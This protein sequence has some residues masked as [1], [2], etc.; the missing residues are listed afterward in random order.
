MLKD[1]TAVALKEAVQVSMTTLPV[2]VTI[3]AL[4][5]FVINTIAVT[6]QT[7]G[8][9]KVVTLLLLRNLL[10]FAALE[11]LNSPNHKIF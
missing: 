7:E 6:T 9:Q 11:H 1:L 3:L 2:L 8:D 4:Q 10:M 5:K